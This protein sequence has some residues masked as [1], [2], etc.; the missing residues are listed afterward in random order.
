MKTIVTRSTKQRV[1]VAK[2]LI[3]SAG[4]QI[5]SVHFITRGDGAMR[6]MS[7]R[8]HVMKPQYA[9]VPSG[10]RQYDPKKYNLAVVFDVNSL[11]YNRRDKLC[12]RGSW[13]SIPMDSITRIKTGGE[14]YR[15][16]S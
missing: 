11:R 3:E 10:K 16:V 6:K 7:C 15:F 8:N 14:I 1:R 12:G 13:K 2:K 9:G 4:N 5:F